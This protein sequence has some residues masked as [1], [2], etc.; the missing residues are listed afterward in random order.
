MSFGNSQIL[1]SSGNSVAGAPPALVP[2]TYVGSGP[3]ALGLSG[4]AIQPGTASY[5]QGNLS[6]A[7]SATL[8]NGALRLT[9]V[10][11]PVPCTL[12]QLFAEFTAAGDAASLFATCIYADS[13]AGSPGS[14]LITGPTISTGS[15][16]AGT[17][18]TGGTPGVYAGTI[19]Q[20][21]LQPGIYWIGGVIQ[22]VTVTQ[23]T[24]R[25]GLWSSSSLP[26]TALPAANAQATSYSVG[27]ITGA[28]PG[29]AGFGG[30]GITPARVGFRIV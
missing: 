19:P 12:Q 5:Y 9:A 13:G 1:G 22:G 16:N 24:M 8:G 28:L 3:A 23:P 29:S 20:V 27:G 17:V 6:V 14:L 18:A 2:P 10:Y 11:I 30:S 25:T 7:T 15:G 26:A 4:V 21:T